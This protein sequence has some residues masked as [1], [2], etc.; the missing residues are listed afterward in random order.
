MTEKISQTDRRILAELQR[1]ASR[2]IDAIAEA[3]GLSRNA[4]WRRM[5][6]LRASG[7]IRKTVAI[8]D[9]AKLDLHLTVLMQIRTDRHDPSWAADF[10]RHAAA[11]PQIT[12]VLRMTGD[13]DYL[14]EA[15]VP[16]MAAY[17]ALY[18][19]LTARIAIA[20]VSASFVMERIKD[21]TALPL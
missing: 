20:D 21:E 4:C 17:D 15:Q 12:R 8:L 2:S 10:A 11:E 6:D 16:D 3:V 19:R 7:A 1:D 13:L 14:V 9:A 18:R 5:R